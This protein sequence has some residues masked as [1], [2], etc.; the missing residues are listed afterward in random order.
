LSTVIVNAILPQP[1]PR[2]VLVATVPVVAVPAVTVP[3]AYN[4]A[5]VITGEA[6]IDTDQNH[7]YVGQVMANRQR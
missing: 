3:M 6:R 5:T 7:G 2:P 4:Y 1:F